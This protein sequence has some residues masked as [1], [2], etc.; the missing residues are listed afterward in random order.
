VSTV[1]D[2]ASRVGK[3]MHDAITALVASVGR[4]DALIDELF[5]SIAERERLHVLDMIRNDDDE[6]A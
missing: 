4:N 2:D 3:K 5:A 1:E 6:P